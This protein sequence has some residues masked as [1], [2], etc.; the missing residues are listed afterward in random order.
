MLTAH[1]VLLAFGSRYSQ[2]GTTS[3]ELL[4][5]AVIPIAACN[6]SWTVLRLAGRLTALVVSSAVYS[7]AIC[8]LAWI[9]APHGLVALTAAWPIGATLTA[10]IAAVL[11][12]T[13]SSKA[14]DAIA[15]ANPGMNAPLAGCSR[16][17]ASRALSA[18]VLDRL[19]GYAPPGL[20]D[21]QIHDTS[22]L[23]R[24]FD[25]VFGEGF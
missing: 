14:P 2:H 25:A 5:V 9:L 17:T 15:A 10:A 13:V 16:P 21:E 19:S 1:W 22:V 6:W 12:A 7:S 18:K 11:S 4:A 8:G 24:R 23:N 20:A 3:L